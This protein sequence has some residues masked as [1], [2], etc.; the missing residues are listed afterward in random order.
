MA[1]WLAQG[2]IPGVGSSIPARGNL[3]QKALLVYLGG[4]ALVG[5][6]ARLSF[7]ATDHN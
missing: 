2:T 6:I 7:R 5:Q 1:V 3:R 4:I